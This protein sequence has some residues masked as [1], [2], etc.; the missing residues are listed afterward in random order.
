MAKQLVFVE[1]EDGRIIRIL[2]TTAQAWRL[3]AE[4]VQ[5]LAKSEAVKAIREQVVARSNGE[6]EDCG[7]RITPVTGE[8]HERVPRGKGGE[9][10]LAN[11]CFLC[12]YCHQGPNGEHGDRYWGGRKGT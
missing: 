2:R 3:P 11:C 12:Y 7:R 9:V 4:R 5:Q 6:C 10:S 1:V 8:M